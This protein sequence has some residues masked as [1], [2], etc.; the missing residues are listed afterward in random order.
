MILHSIEVECALTSKSVG[1]IN[2]FR[3]A[4]QRQ[5]NDARA[6]VSKSNVR[7]LRGCI[8]TLIGGQ[9]R[10]EMVLHN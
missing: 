8:E 6:W 7:A 9:S 3:V 4:F 2:A 5:S 1:L 10:S